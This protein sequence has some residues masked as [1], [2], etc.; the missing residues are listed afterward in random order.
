[1][2]FHC[3]YCSTA[4]KKRGLKSQI[5]G[6]F[7]GLVSVSP[8]TAAPNSR[9]NCRQPDM[10]HPIWVKSSL[11]MLAR[12]PS[13]CAATHPPRPPGWMGSLAGDVA[14]THPPRPPGVVVG[15]AGLVQG[16]EAARPSGRVWEK[17]TGS[18]PARTWAA[19][20]RFSARVRGPA[21]PGPGPRLPGPD[22][23]LEEDL[24]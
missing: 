18:S 22:G 3:R 11:R 4:G 8:R 2:G 23:L 19:W 7:R 6:P 13:E 21:P 5:S 24:P 10:A 9:R 12:W 1:M 17:R 20:V 14:A 16:G 15:H